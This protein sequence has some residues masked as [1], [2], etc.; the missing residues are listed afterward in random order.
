MARTMR[1][2]AEYLE[3]ENVVQVVGVAELCGDPSQGH[4]AAEASSP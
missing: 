2:M 3:G 4:M 1:A